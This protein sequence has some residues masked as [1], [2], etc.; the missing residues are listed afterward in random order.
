ME[1]TSEGAG[2]SWAVPPTATPLPEQLGAHAAAHA[3]HRD[4]GEKRLSSELARLQS[5]APGPS[6][7]LAATGNRAGRPSRGRAAQRLDD[8]AP[9][10]VEEV[11]GAQPSKRAAQFALDWNGVTHLQRPRQLAMLDGDE[12]AAARAAWDAAVNSPEQQDLR[13]QRKDNARTCERAN[14][15]T[16][17]RANVPRLKK[18]RND[19]Y[20]SGAR[21][22]RSMTSTAVRAQ[23]AQVPSHDYS[24]APRGVARHRTRVRSARAQTHWHART[25]AY[26][27]EWSRDPQ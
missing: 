5:G 20:G 8:L 13:K 4:G 3:M 16:C 11:Q 24:R 21:A 10:Q 12:L 2:P 9:A 19:A 17:E 18:I 23:A 15:R 1:S 26:T 7:R 6:A 27:R 22:R 25:I 14:V